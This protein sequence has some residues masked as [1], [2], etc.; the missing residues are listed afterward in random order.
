MPP[1]TARALVHASLCNQAIYRCS[2]MVR[3]CTANEAL[4]CVVREAGG[5]SA[6]MNLVLL[7]ACA[8]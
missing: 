2:W 7:A 5:V 8:S 6:C 1:A 4:Q 3:I